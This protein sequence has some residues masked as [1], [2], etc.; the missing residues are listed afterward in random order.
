M[1][2]YYTVGVNK[3]YVPVRWLTEIRDF[4][5]Q[6][7]G[8]V[9]VGEK[10]F[11]YI[12]IILAIIILIKNFRK[13]DRFWWV[14]FVSFLIEVLLMRNYK[15]VRSREYLI[16]FHSIIILICSWITVEYFKLNKF[17]GGLILG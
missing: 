10:Y 14:L 12:L 11:G 7:F 15:G 6:L 4:W 13:I 17:A 8:D 16:A 9:V 1:I 3:F 2:E 5:P